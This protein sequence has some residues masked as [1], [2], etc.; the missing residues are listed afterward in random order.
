MRGE[1]LSRVA[2]ILLLL[3]VAGLFS[4]AEISLLSL[5]N[6]RARRLGAGLSGRLLEPMLARPAY[7]LGSVLVAITALNYTSE[8]LAAGWVLTR[9]HLPVWV[10]VL[11]MSVLVLVLAEMVPI[12]YASANPERVAGLVAFPLW[13]ASWVLLLPSR[14]LAFIAESL[15]R[16]VGGKPQP[17]IPVTEGEIRA[18]V[19]LQTEAGGLEAEE[20]VMIHSIFEFGDK[21]AREVMVPRV[22]MLAAPLTATAWEAA[23][24]LTEHRLSRLPLY[25]DSI[26]HVVGIVYVKELLPAL[27]AGDRALAAKALMK[28]PLWVP[29]TKRLQDLLDDFRRQQKTV[30]IVL[31]EYGGTAGLVTMEDL[32]EEVVGDIWDEYD[33]IRPHVVPLGPGLFELDGRI[34]IAEASEALGLALPEGEYD[35]LAGLMYDRLSVVPRVDDRVVLS[36]VAFTVLETDGLRIARLRAEL[37]PPAPADDAEGE[38]G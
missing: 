4:A 22:A 26:D 21:V 3:A 6:R 12:S 38:G 32:L 10:A 15:A 18:I 27:S 9:L 25:R 14:L 31:D 33:V 30:A 11:A 19:D 7:V 23:Q 16:L 37:T 17:E 28:P 2:L 24:L 8:A 13:L 1:D 36:G 5:S 29:E 35:S 34:S 20:K